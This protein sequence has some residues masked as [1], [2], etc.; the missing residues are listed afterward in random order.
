[1]VGARDGIFHVAQHRIDPFEI[2]NWE[3]SG[4]LDVSKL[5]WTKP[6]ETLLI[7]DVQAHSLQGG[8]LALEDNQDQDLVQGGQLLFAVF[9]L[10]PA[11]LEPLTKGRWVH[12]SEEI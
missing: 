6:G 2:G 4:V 1:M 5:F 3:S 10:K 9:Q 11:D 12:I 7:L 8:G